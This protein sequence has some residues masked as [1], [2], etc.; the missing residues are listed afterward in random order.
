LISSY[1]PDFRHFVLILVFYN[2]KFKHYIDY[3]LSSFWGGKIQEKFIMMIYQIDKP[4][5]RKVFQEEGGML[6]IDPDGSLS[7]VMQFPGLKENELEAFHRGFDTYGYLESGTTPPIAFWTWNWTHPLVPA[8]ANFNAV[9]ADK[10][11]INEYLKE[12]DGGGVKNAILFLL[13]DRQILRGMK[14]FALDPVAVRA[15][16]ATIRKQLELNR[17]SD[18]FMKALKGMYHFTTDELYAMSQKFNR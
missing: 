6:H 7:Y 13:I 3:F 1:Y 9:I 4:F 14:Y 5:P 18:E 8:D 2:A 16:H 15:F 10:T 11:G 12:A 17:S